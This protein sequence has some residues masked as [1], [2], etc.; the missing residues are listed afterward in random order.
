MVKVTPPAGA[1]VVEGQS[2]TAPV[3]VVREDGQWR[4]DM[5]A[6]MQRMFGGSLDTMVENMGQAMGKAMEAVGDAMSKAF[7]GLGGEPAKEEP[8]QEEPA[9]QEPPK[10][11][12]RRKR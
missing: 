3:I 4:L 7:E 1:P 8:V 11:K 6:S 2:M 12:R 9:K 10:A 5:L